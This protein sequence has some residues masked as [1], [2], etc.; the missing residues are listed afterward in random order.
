MSFNLLYAA[1]LT[2]FHFFFGGLFTDLTLFGRTVPALAVPIL[3]AV[4]GN[5]AFLLYDYLLT[6]MIFLYYT[7]W[8]ARIGRWLR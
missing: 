1:I 7:K 8:S 4:L 6:R 3:L 2:V 5:L